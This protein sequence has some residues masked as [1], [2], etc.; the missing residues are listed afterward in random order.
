MK[1]NKRV[2]GRTDRRV[3][4]VQKHKNYAPINK[5]RHPGLPERNT[6]LLERSEFSHDVRADL[7]L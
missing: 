7:I 4:L 1:L 6:I 3:G 2:D 5:F